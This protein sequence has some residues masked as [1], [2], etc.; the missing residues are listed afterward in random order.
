V[1]TEVKSSLKLDVHI[2]IEREVFNFIFEDIRKLLEKINRSN[3]ETLEEIRLR[4]NKPVMIINRSGDWFVDRDGKLSKNHVSSYGV[5]QWE[6]AK[7][8]ELMSENS[9]YAFQED[10]RNGFITLKGG[11][12]VGVAGKA[13]MDGSSIKSIKD[14][15][16]LN[17]RLSREVY[18]CSEKVIKH[19]INK[20]SVYNTLIISPPQCGKTTILR[21]VAR[22][23]SDGID[24]Y[25]FKGKKVGIIDERSEIAACYKGIPQ[26]NVG[27]RT[28]VL[29]ACPKR[30][31]MS[32]MLRS[33]SPDV[34]ITDEIGNDGD[35]DAVHKV[36]NAGVKII[37]SAHGYNISELKSRQEVLSLIK[38]RVFERYI[39]LSNRQGPGTV[40]E[41]IDGISMKVRIGNDT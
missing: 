28:D 4:A 7:T 31:G 33:M 3:L 24:E 15:S 8:L 22:V 14:I 35:R 18:G 34:I 32:I 16:G 30:L 19:I 12:R 13:V 9:I 11:H 37:T 27:V 21:D 5:R 41:V 40:E 26:N 29:D 2:R 1:I 25:N 10:I 6:I 17:I 39:V 20:N 36:I 23:L 38:E